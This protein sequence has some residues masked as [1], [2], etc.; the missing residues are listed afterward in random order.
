MARVGPY[1][2]G[3]EPG[4]VG[5]LGPISGTNPALEPVA[6]NYL[7]RFYAAIRCRATR[8]FVEGGEFH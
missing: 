2:H 4:P 3:P 1:D 6:E 5:P 8:H 7:P